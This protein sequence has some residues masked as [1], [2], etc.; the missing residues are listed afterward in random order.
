MSL[1]TLWG[2]Y[3]L[4]VVTTNWSVS[5]SVFHNV[6]IGYI[7]FHELFVPTITK[8]TDSLNGLQWFDIYHQLL[9]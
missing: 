8:S 3:Q 4:L 6:A 7:Y 2:N 1:K 5:H 9:A